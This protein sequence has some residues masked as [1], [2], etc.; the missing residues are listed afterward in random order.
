MLG[1]MAI[2]RRTFLYTSPLVLAPLLPGCGDDPINEGPPFLHGV[3]SGDPLEDAVV[4]WT[5]VSADQGAPDAVGVDWTIATD[6]RFEN[7]VASGTAGTDESVDYTVKVDVGGL[8]PGTTYYSRFTALGYD[9]P[10]GRTRTARTGAIDRLRF[11]LASCANYPYGFFNAYAAIARRPDLDAV[12]H[13][14]DYIYEYSE[15]DYGTGAPLGR[16]PDP[17]TEAL[18]LE[19]YR[20]RHAQYKKDPDLQEAHRQHPFIAI[21]D[22]HEVAND[23]W[24]D[25]AENHQPDEGDYSARKT[26]A[27][28]AYFEWMP[29]R[30][31][32]S[33]DQKT[34][35]RSF[36]FGDLVDLIMLDTRHLA[37]DQQVANAC[38]VMSIANPDRQLLGVTQES[39]FLDQISRS[40]ARGARW[41]LVG[42]QV[43]MAQLI[44]VLA[45]G[46]CI[47]NPDQW[48]GYAAARARVLSTLADNAIGNVVVLTGD[49]HSSWGNDLTLQPFDPA[50]Y[51]PASGSGSIA[52]EIVTPAV[53]SPSITEDPATAAQLGGA[54]L[55]THP[56][57]KYV[58]IIRRGY[59]LL[60]VTPERVQAEWYHMATIAERRPDEALAA[61]LQVLS[62]QNHLVAAPE[63]SMPRDDAA[64]LAPAPAVGA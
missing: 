21:W 46:N 19:D 58:E 42:Q 50:V 64:P 4:I 9:S 55:T 43:M 23:A 3:A 18:T 14:G 62:G 33:D 28:R 27:L 7:V 48:D 51:D 17:P 47:F 15:G 61:T 53:T 25:G 35:Y 20:R 13:L 10:I 1:P 59:T 60:D 37:R 45:P 38:D 5:R 16:T 34:V 63:A 32:L 8:E 41:R 54:V 24:R 12:L 56:H 6:A 52:V 57:V 40:Q 31:T 22:D 29:V 39:W 11:A 36:A 30:A 44:N 26:A 2:S 49:I